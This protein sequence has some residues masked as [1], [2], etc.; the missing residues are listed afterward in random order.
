MDTF[1]VFKDNLYK[2][3]SQIRYSYGSQY[4]DFTYKLVWS[5]ILRVTKDQGRP[6]A[7]LYCGFRDVCMTFHRERF[8]SYDKVQTQNSK[9]RNKRK[10]IYFKSNKKS[11]IESLDKDVFLI[12]VLNQ[13]LVP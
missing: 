8:V 7:Y 5:E 11:Y 10:T 12:R 3:I 4:K 9:L 1:I 13:K 2:R 6:G